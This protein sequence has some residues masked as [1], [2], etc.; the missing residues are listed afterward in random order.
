MTYN[1]SQ[2]T[3]QVLEGILMQRVNSDYT[4]RIIVADDCS[5]DGTLDS[6]KTYA[7]K[8][9][10]KWVFLPCERNLGISKNYQRGFAAS[11]ADYVAV[12]EGDDYWCNPMHLQN[13]VDF[14]EL[15]GECVL[16]SSRMFIKD[17]TK[18]IFETYYPQN[19]DIVY[20]GMEQAR[21]NK[22]GN[23]STCVFRGELVR[24]LPSSMFELEVDDW[25]LG[26]ELCKYGYIGK[27][28][29]PTSVYRINKNSKW[30][31]MSEFEQVQRILERIDKYD[32]F[33][34]GIYHK[35]FMELRHE[36]INGKQT[37][38][39]R[40]KQ[41]VPPFFVS[42]MKWILPPALIKLC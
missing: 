30:A 1:Q 27:L 25:L 12:I 18:N 13:H 40:I 38:Y 31:A 20:S 23:L 19:E 3:R 36:L 41:Y 28:S 34:E 26:L 37:K 15:H 24:A 11:T 42:L 29:T 22:I 33:L 4:V 2:Y 9:E 16:S 5:T 6:I 8:H 39:G 7:L 35:A 14:L 21:F 10:A 17:E 32:D